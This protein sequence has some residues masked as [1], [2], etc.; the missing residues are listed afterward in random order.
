MTSKL[1]K[2]ALPASV[3]AVVLALVVTPASAQ[4]SVT[5]ASFGGVT[6]DAE[7]EELFADAGK[8]GVQIRNERSG[9]WPGIKAY[10]LSG[11]KGWDLTSIG[12][13]RCEEAAKSDLVLPMD[14]SV[15]D[16]AKTLPGLAREKYVGVYNFGYGI[17]YQKKKYG[18]NTPQ[19]WAD[20]WD[21]KKFP[22]RRSMIG[23][24]LYNLE[25]A[26]MADGVPKEDVYKVLKAPGGVDRA[27]KKLEEIKPDVA[28]W[29][30]SPAQAVEIMRSGEVDMAIVPNGRTSAA[31]KAGA[32]IGYVWNQAFVDFECFLI[33][34]SAPNPGAAMK[35]INASL[36]AK[37]QAKF[38]ARI[39]Y[40]PVN[41]AA[42]DQ[43]VLAIDD[44]A[45]LPSAKQNI[46]K[47][48]FA[49]PTWYSSP[50]A[51]AAYQRFAKF[52]Q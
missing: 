1:V 29:W 41:Q 38:A 30:R 47:Q 39:G 15:I 12:F 6:Q 23:E 13:A 19:T 51:D 31:V 4:G 34:K 50:E 46:D 25:A 3:I 36:D 48:V 21:T 43:G 44:V 18:A 2:C 49:D 9:A 10:L 26:L 24:G 27:M 35:L 37:N 5:F 14:Y 8:L 20:F 33:P 42:F 22:G 17:G 32:D 45:W 16:K 52:L 11:A 7:V 40:G 28:V